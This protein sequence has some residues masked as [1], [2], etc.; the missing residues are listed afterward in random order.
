[1]KRN[2]WLA[3]ALVMLLVGPIAVSSQ[4]PVK[5][6]LLNAKHGQEADGL[7]ALIDA[8]QQAHP[9]ITIE[10]VYNPSGTITSSFQAAAGTGEGPDMII[11][12]NDSVGPWATAHLIADISSGVDDTLK[13]QATDSA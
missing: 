2:F 10:Q 12:A 5:L 4:S 7:L 6:V 3:L 8:F 11:W 9:D 13:A 1:M